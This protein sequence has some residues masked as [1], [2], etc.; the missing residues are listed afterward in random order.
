[1]KLDDFKKIPRFTNCA[2]ETAQP[3]WVETAKRSSRAD[4]LERRERQVE[5]TTATAG[6]KH[7][8][9][10]VTDAVTDSRIRCRSRTPQ[11]HS[12]KQTKDSMGAAKAM[13]QKAAKEQTGG[14]SAGEQR[15]AWD[16]V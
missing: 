3:C 15:S 7:I 2:D 10:A 16:N 8:D 6:R 4:D 9:S 13:K 14:P 11:E 12:E 5:R 1:M